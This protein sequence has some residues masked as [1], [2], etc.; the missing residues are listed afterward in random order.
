MSAP[1]NILIVDDDQIDRAMVRRQL[2]DRAADMVLHEAGTATEAIDVLNHISIDCLLLDYRL[3]GQDGIEFYKD[4]KVGPV[5]FPS[6]VIMLTGQGN[7]TAAVEAMKCGVRDYLVKGQTTPT[8]LSSSIERAIGVARTE[9]ELATANAALKELA[10]IDPVTQ[11]GNRHHF[12]LRLSHA[13]DRAQRQVETVGLIIMDL[14]GF[15]M[16]NDTYG[17]I[18]G[19]LV[20]K[21]V[22]SRLEQCARKSDTVARLGGDEFAIIMESGV[23]SDGAELFAERIET[24]IGAPMTFNDEN[25]GV[26]ASIGIALFPKNGGTPEMLFRAADDAMYQKKRAT[27]A[28]ASGQA[29]AAEYALTPLLAERIGGIGAE[30]PD[31]MREKG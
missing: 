31:F 23:S 17:H 1:L 16:V 9:Q 22:A 28:P 7:E 29:T 15:K 24:L 8:S 27:T 26:G 13:L 10:L 14:D 11:I 21:E 20:L 30:Q 12:D 5:R 4:L 6:A 2:S 3:S 19:D 18:T 25:V